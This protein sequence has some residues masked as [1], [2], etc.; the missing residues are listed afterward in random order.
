MGIK[1]YG[2]V[3]IDTLYTGSSINA[4]G[5]HPN[6]GIWGTLDEQNQELSITVEE[7][8]PQVHNTPLL[9]QSFAINLYSRI[10]ANLY[11]QKKR[12]VHN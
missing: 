1:F 4:S 7:K 2:E 6:L 5:F 11:K 9:L 10:K 12:D 8:H 3:V